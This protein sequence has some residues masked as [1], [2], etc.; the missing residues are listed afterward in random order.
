MKIY[1]ILVEQDLLID[2]L[3]IL[4]NATLKFIEKNQLIIFF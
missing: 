4:L 1:L 3:F 2:F